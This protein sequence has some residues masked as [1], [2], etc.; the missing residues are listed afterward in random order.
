MTQTTLS[1]NEVQQVLD[2]LRDLAAEQK[3]TNHRRA[4]RRKVALPLWLRR[5][6]GCGSE[7]SQLFRI[8]AVDISNKGIGCLSRRKLEL[9]ETF[10]LPLRFSEGGGQLV[11][12]RVRFLR[13]LASGHFRVGAEFAATTPDPTGR[14]RIPEEW[15][16]DELD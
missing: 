3:P 12:C 6:P 16:V 11:L 2:V 15:L 1:H 10:V 9:G 4:L 14:A 13:E 7:R 5:I 8:M